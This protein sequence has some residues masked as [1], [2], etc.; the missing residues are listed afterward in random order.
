MS[1]VTRML[2]A[3]DRGD[4][5]TAE[6][7]LPLVYDELRKLAAHRMANEAP[8]QTLQPTALVHEAWLRLVGSGQEHW[9][10]RGHFF[11]AAAEAMRRILVERARKKARVRHGGELERVD[12]DH[13]TVAAQDNDDT[14]LAIHEALDK[15]AAQSPQKAE[16]V[17]LRYFAGMEHAE[18]AEALGVSEPTARRHWACARSWLYAELKS[19]IADRFAGEKAH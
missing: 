18:I 15:L 14:I 8:G 2:S 3:I 7:L 6:E 9:N 13:V 4:P 12:L 19:Q 10:S 16:V 11:G 1:D 17:K 5:K